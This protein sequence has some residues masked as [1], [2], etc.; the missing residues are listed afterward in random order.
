VLTQADHQ[1]QLLPHPVV[2]CSAITA[3]LLLPF[4]NITPP[5]AA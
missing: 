2:T 4:R 1:Y 5:R 3:A